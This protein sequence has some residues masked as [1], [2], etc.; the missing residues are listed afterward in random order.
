MKYLID[1]QILIWML[2]L[3]DRLPKDIVRILINPQ[4]DIIVSMASIWEIAIKMSIGKLNVPFEFKNIYDEIENLNITI[5]NIK[6]EHIS[7]I[8]D[9]PFHHKD[10]FDRL[11]ISQAIFENIPVISSDRNFKFYN[12]ECIW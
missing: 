5:L 7:K 2:G 1:T 8:I 6:T 3:S 11:I 4:N 12:I 10:P 9:L